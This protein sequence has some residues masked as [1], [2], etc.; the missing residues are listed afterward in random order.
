MV[1]TVLALDIVIIEGII[2]VRPAPG[3]DGSR[4]TH[5]GI[6][7]SRYHSVISLN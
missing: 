7:T 5:V 1:K 6:V 3:A 2:A 4:A